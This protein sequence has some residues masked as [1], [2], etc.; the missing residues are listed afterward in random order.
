MLNCSTC[1]KKK[2]I[3]HFYRYAGTHT[4]WLPTSATDEDTDALARL[5]ADGIVSPTPGRTTQ[6]ASR[7]NMARV[8]ERLATDGRPPETEDARARREAAQDEARR[9]RERQARADKL[10]GWGA[11]VGLAGLVIAGAVKLFRDAHG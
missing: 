7:A 10:W 5:I 1:H 4:P 6:R 11:G 8:N 3:E 9:E 2:P